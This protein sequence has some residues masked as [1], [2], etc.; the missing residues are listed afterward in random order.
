VISHSFAFDSFTVNGRQLNES[1]IAAFIG[2]EMGV[3]LVLASGDDQLTKETK[4]MLGPIETVTTK[5]AYSFQGAAV[6][7]L[8]QVHADLR[9]AAMRAVRRARAGE[10]KPLKLER[11]YKVRF[12]LRRN[13]AN[14]DWVRGTVGRF[15][16][17]T[18]D[19]GQGC[20]A[21]TSD[22]AE[23]VGNLLNLVE[24]TVLKP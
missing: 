23:A 18:P 2:G 24:W 5:I 4:E 6:R 3:P 16:G 12:C 21:Y 8:A 7:P 9:A 14:D 22:S 10:L 19:G 11:P 17:V 1:G 15:E 20:F 13:Y